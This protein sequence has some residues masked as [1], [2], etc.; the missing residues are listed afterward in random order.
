MRRRSGRCA[1]ALLALLALQARADGPADA[2]ATGAARLA[3]ITDQFFEEV[4]ELHPVT[5]TFI[6]DH[7]YDDRLP[8]DGPAEREAAMQLERR[9]QA[10]LAVIDRARL[11]PADQ[12]NYDVFAL[13]R[14]L[15][16]EGAAYPAE[17]L[18][19]DQFNNAA[20][21]FAQL[22]SGKT[23]QPFV[24][25]RDYDNFLAR[26][27]AFPAWTDQLISWM[28]EGVHRGVVQP[29]VLMERVLPQ[30]AALAVSGCEQSV[31]WAP[32]AAMP[33]SFPAAERERLTAAYRKAISEQV[34]PAYRRLHDYVRDE[35]LP[36]ARLS[37][38]MS[39][40]PGGAAWYA[41]LARGYTSTD[42][43]VAEI[44]ET[45]LGEVARIRSEIARIGA[46]I[47]FKGDVAALADALRRDPRFHFTRP[48]DLLNAYRS[49]EALVQSA[50]PW[51]FTLVPKA[52][53]EVRPIEAFRAQSQATAE[54]YQPAAD[55][56]RPGIFYVNTYDLPSRPSYEIE[57][58]FLHEAIPG[59][60]FQIALTIENPDLPRF[61]RFGINAALSDTPDP[62]T[63]YVEG[64]G[65]YA[66]S[67][68]EELGLYTDPYQKLG[69]LFNESW[70]AVR[71]VVDT[72][73][74]AR[75]WTR[76]QAIDYML[77]NTAASRI[78]AT[79]EVERYIAMPGQALAYKTGQLTIR[80][81][82]SRAE[83]ALG[84][85]FD[86]REFHAQV[87]GSGAL[88]LSLL[89]AK[90]EHWID[91]SRRSGGTA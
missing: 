51:L 13:N 9:S 58:I 15:A 7:R 10:A 81:L 88:P 74:H 68:G 80:R 48:E 14:R 37:V 42:T 43:P 59:H 30:L 29:R 84:E 12:L 4:L 19:L 70:R 56:S 22:G 34:I 72:G 89:E 55:G 45:G 20:V 50:I 62:T 31:F 46:R 44:H 79:A 54:Y 17:L 32:V 63:A 82:R 49:R 87:L 78:D 24:T 6:G 27:A 8:A 21:F 57:S 66:E 3:Q 26:M 39:A 86:V 33:D 41:Y 64:W 67:L 90:I 76:E 69:S 16:L 47:G 40:L 60:H 73:L 77:A 18:P 71:L 5:A 28:R 85:R 23:V 65:L 11:A 35:Y 52:L 38:G 83:Q 25:V 53:L 1:A 91:E 36:K 75:G 61:R 2:A